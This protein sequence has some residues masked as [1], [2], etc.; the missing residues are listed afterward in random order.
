MS[1]QSRVQFQ[2]NLS[3]LVSIFLFYVKSAHLHMNF[4]VTT[5]SSMAL[6]QKETRKR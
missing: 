5:K 2:F 3:I 6:R 1:V 4:Q